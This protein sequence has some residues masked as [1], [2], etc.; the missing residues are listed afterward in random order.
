MRAFI[1]IELSDDLKEKIFKLQN[2][3]RDALDGKIKWVEKENFHLTLKFL[4]DIKQDK[5]DELFEKIKKP[6]SKIESFKIELKNIGFFPNKKFAKVIWIG[7]SE[8]GKS[9]TTISSCI[10]QTSEKSDKEFHAHISLGRVKGK[11]KMGNLNSMNQ[12]LDFCEVRKVSIIES[13][14]TQTGPIYKTYREIKL[15]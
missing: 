14:I 3:L 15:K 11:I 9:L 10:E 8:Q 6:I 2:K 4:G 5:L 12:S 7:V 13:E 1:A